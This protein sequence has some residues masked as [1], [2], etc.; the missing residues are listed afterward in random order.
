ML[1]KVQ[2][3]K[4]YRLFVYVEQQAG[5]SALLFYFNF[6]FIYSIKKVVVIQ[7]ESSDYSLTLKFSFSKKQICVSSCGCSVSTI[8]TNLGY[9]VSIFSL[10][11]TSRSNIRYPACIIPLKIHYQVL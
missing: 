7:C 10:K 2:D 9:N 11:L 8:A 3:W 4:L 1:V 5:R 6:F